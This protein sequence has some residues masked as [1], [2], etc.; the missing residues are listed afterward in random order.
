MRRFAKAEP[1]ML[2]AVLSLAVA[3]GALFVPGLPDMIGAVGAALI[4]ASARA[5]V[6]PST[7]GVRRR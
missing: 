4:Q 1:V 3:L 6:S 7:V 5:K 2:R